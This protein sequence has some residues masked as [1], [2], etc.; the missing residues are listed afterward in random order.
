MRVNAGQNGCEI[1]IPTPVVNGA[2]NYGGTVYANGSRITSLITTF[3]GN[4]EATHKYRECCNGSA[5]MIYIEE[6]GVAT[7]SPSCENPHGI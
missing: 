2:C 6:C 1:D 4:H 5:T 7:N 3:C